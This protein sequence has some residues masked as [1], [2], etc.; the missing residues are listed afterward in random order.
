MSLRSTSSVNRGWRYS[1]CPLAS[2]S[3][4]GSSASAVSVTV[5]HPNV[6]LPAQGFDDLDYQ[7]VSSYRRRLRLPSEAAGMRACIRFGGVMSTATVF[8]NGEP[9]G[10]HHGGFLPF[11]CELTEHLRWDGEDEIAVEVDS[12]EHADQPPFGGH[13][14]YLTFG[15]M[16]RGVQLTLLPR[17]F[18]ADVFVRPH[19]VLTERRRIEVRYELDR[20]DA[21]AANGLRVEAQVLAGDRVIA[22]SS[23]SVSAQWQGARLHGNVMITGLDELD[24]WDVDNPQLYDVRLQL[25]DG[26][27]ELDADT[28]RTGL[29]EAH[30]TEDG[31]FLNGRRLKLRGLNRHQTYPHVG[32]AMPDRVQRR[33]AQILHDE[34]KCNAVRTSHYP[35]APSFLDACDELGLLV[36]EE[37]PGWQHI[38]DQQWQ[39]RACDDV[40]GMVTRDRNHPSIILWGVRINE[41]FDSEDFYRRTNDIAHRLDDS[42]Q[43]SG[44]R[45]FRE[46]QLLEDVFALNDFQT[47][48]RIDLPN[49]PRYLVSEFAGHMF[50]TKRF[51]NVERVQEHAIL[52][53]TVLD[54]VH[55][56]PRIAGSFGW[57][58]FD[59]ATH[60][61]FG[62]GN[63]VCYHGVADM[64][65]VPKP[66]ASV[67]RSQCPP[68]HEV[69]LEPAFIWAGGDHSDYGGPGK[70]LILSNC[71]RIEAFVGGTPVGQLRPDRAGF[72]HL[73][74]PPFFFA[75]ESGIAPW[76]REWGE[77]RLDGYL[78]DELVIT[79]ILS[80]RGVDHMMSVALDDIT[81]AADGADATRLVMQVTDEYGN[82]RPFAT[83][84]LQISVTGPATV[85]GDNPIAL[86]GGVAVVWLRAGEEPGEVGITVTHPTLGATSVGITVQKVAG[87]SW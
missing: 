75:A 9:L 74:N 15:G 61:E 85:V 62:S 80:G 30:F 45:Y 53:A 87:E 22:A 4:D 41:S 48:G 40:A 19:D 8:C 21:D 24:L 1:P 25:L 35:Q 7:F 49:H 31:F 73:P 23:G 68:Q 47:G 2:A 38:G 27:T 54:A 72:P 26:D 10:T 42:R 12:T 5:P 17:T 81:L 67:Y 82:A 57:C 56:D 59:Y 66:A 16:Y 6:V 84:A 18:I 29:R 32:A 46:S 52:H 63:R 36:F 78:D 83:G 60:Q 58:A 76:R 20:G 34:L 86:T 55:A 77:L 44:V 79:R 51:D 28:V 37:M 14:D 3:E 69:I 33:D 13:I 50:P 39:D 71:T 65:R 70:G 64:F 11:T 43:T